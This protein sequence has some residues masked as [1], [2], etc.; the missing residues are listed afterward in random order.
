[1]QIE[2]ASLDD[3]SDVK[4]DVTTRKSIK[5]Y[6]VTDEHGKLEINE[7]KSGPLDRQDLQSKDSFIIDNGNFGIWAWIGKGASTKERLEAMNNAQS[8]IK[9]KSY[10]EHT[11]VT[12]VIDGAE[13]VEF[14]SLFRTWNDKNASDMTKVVFFLLKKHFSE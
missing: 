10:P 12:R 13:P 7:V 14:K 2:P 1:M 4:Q 9:T 3:E 5:L 6:R 11:Q 8:F